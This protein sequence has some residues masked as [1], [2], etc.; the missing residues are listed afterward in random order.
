[1][2]DVT[3]QETDRVKDIDRATGADRVQ[4]IERVKVFYG[5]ERPLCRCEDL[6]SPKTF[7]C[8]YCKKKIA[9]DSPAVR[10]TFTHVPDTNH[11]I[12]AECMEPAGYAES[13]RRMDNRAYTF[14]QFN[15]GAFSP[16]IL[17]LFDN[18]DFEKALQIVI[19]PPDWRKQGDASQIPKLI[20]VLCWCGFG[21]RLVAEMKSMPD[22]VW[23]LLA[24]RDEEI[25]QHEA[26]RLFQANDLPKSMN[27]LHKHRLNLEDMLLVASFGKAHPNFRFALAQ[28]LHLYHL[29]K[30]Y[31]FTSAK[32]Y[33]FAGF[34]M[35]RN[36]QLCYFFI[37]S[38]NEFPRL[39]EFL[40]TREMPPSYPG[41]LLYS[42]AAYYR[43]IVL[44]LIL[45][46][47]EALARDWMTAM[48]ARVTFYAS[49]SPRGFINDTIKMAGQLLRG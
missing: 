24:M 20:G 21:P 40:Q 25:F 41:S 37:E 45:N 27:V 26:A 16:P 15:S 44:H 14:K 18:F 11:M 35:A 10:I 36:A 38:P 29:D 39:K 43:A 31:T 1:M 49:G 22:Y 19:D 30:S 17:S 48:P 12:H 32:A 13:R 23:I 28:A 3:N 4:E 2:T 8:L 46:G 9:Q 42:T 6:P 33:G 5:A 7:K 34:D 47:N